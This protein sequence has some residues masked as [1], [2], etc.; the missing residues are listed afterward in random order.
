MLLDCQYE[1]YSFL[2]V[3]NK[4][5]RFT[6]RI[7]VN[8]KDT[9]DFSA[10]RKAVDTAIKRYPYFSVK[11]VK[12][13]NE[14]D[15]VPNEKPIP[16][17]NSSD[18]VCL[19]TDETNGH[20]IAVC[21][22]NNTVNFDFYHGLTDASGATPF[23]QSVLYYYITERCGKAID[24]EGIRLADDELL[25]DETC[26]PLSNTTEFPDEPLYEY[27]PQPAFNFAKYDGD[28]DNK[29]TVYYIDVDEK[30]LMELS[31]SSDGTPNSI[32]AA[33]LYKTILRL[34]PDVEEPIV[35]GV[36]INSRPALKMQNNYADLISLMKL[37]Y[38]IKAKDY[39][40]NRL[41]TL[42]RGMIIL[43][44]Q[45]E[46]MLFE[47]KNRMKFAEYLK[48][49]PSDKARQQAYKGVVD[50]NRK[51]SSFGIS[52]VGRQ[53]WY[54]LEPYID[55]VYTATM[56]SKDSLCVEINVIN[57]TFG[58][59]FSQTFSSDKYVKAFMQILSEQN[60]PHTFKGKSDMNIASAKI[61]DE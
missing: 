6:Y 55:S 20:L 7:I 48:T 43:Q 56:P 12:H 18:S 57:G 25:P 9:V 52:Y 47:I 42:G 54:S 33:M 10:M 36:A 17:I 23:I 59:C 24:C 30:S 50:N 51:F 16:V 32:V 1:H 19:G 40:L 14:Y 15:V 29:E 37:N 27:T 45:P 60:I 34:Y 38:P 26:S 35:A 11:V 13:G 61:L 4:E 22:E 53:R 39:D 44:S 2:Y 21:C 49:L 31:K 46:N 41:G 5:M 3:N 58:V 8:L 28:L